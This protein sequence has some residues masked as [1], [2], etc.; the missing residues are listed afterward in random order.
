M[1]PIITSSDINN[2]IK[3]MP[4]INLVKKNFGCVL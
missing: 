1:L 2:Y 4:F 3:Y